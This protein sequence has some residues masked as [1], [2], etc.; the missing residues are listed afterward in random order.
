[1]AASFGDALDA[2]AAVRALH[3]AGF[4]TERISIAVHDTGIAERATGDTGLGVV[5]DP[6]AIMSDEHRGPGG[7]SVGTT[8]LIIPGVGIIIGGPLAVTLAE[9]DAR[10]RTGGLAA[11]L[12]EVGIPEAE[13]RRYQE[14][15]DAG[16]VLVVVAAGDR[17][18]EAREILGDRGRWT[19]RDELRPIPP[20][21]APPTT[22]S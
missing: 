22:G 5:E 21:D 6:G 20:S 14:S 2:E 12:S 9:P 3:D 17:E 19:Y 16:E 4:G 8:G 10:A 1:M 13:A 7:V 15:Y 18:R 11:A